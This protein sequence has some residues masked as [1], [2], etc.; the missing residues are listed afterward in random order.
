M[1]VFIMDAILLY[2]FNDYLMDLGVSLQ[3]RDYLQEKA[4]HTAVIFDNQEN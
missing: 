1:N 4:R 2:S 3:V